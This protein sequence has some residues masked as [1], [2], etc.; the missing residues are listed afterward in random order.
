[1]LG[2]DPTLTGTSWIVC[3]EPSPSEMRSRRMPTSPAT[4]SDGG[5]TKLSQSNPRM[6]QQSRHFEVRLCSNPL[7]LTV[8]RLSC[9]IS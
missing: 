9:Q 6:V 5:L 7:Q 4:A 2:E 3:P 1:M 8:P